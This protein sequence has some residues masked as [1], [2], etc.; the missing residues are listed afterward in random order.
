MATDYD[1]PRRTR[2]EEPDDDALDELQ[3]RRGDRR[4][5]VPDVD[6]PDV[7]ES[8]ELPGA[9]LSGEELNVRVIPKRADEFTCTRCFLVQHRSRLVDTS[10]GQM[11]CR[12]CV[13]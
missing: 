12:D 4:S 3:T 11:I 6:E 7:I 10:D 8:F 5:G 1:A 9:D 13:G 2:P